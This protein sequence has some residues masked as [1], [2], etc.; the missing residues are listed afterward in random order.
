MDVDPDVPTPDVPTD[1]GSDVVADTV[2]DV[3]EDV[4]V[5]VGPD[6]V[7]TDPQTQIEAAHAAV[8][9]ASELPVMGSWDIDG[10]T[11]TYLKDAIGNDPAGFFIQAEQTGPGLFVMYADTVTMPAV[12]DTVAFTINA[13]T[14]T[15]GTRMATSITTPTVLTSGADVGALVQE[16]SDVD[17]VA[18]LDDYASELIELT[19]IAVGDFGFAGSG[20][21]AIS[22]QTDGYFSGTEIRLR[23]PTDVMDAV[24]ASGT[25]EGCEVSV[26][27]TPLWRFAATPQP[28]AQTIDELAVVCPAPELLAAAATG[29]TT[30]TLMFS[31]PIDAMSVTD[32]GTQFSIPGL[33]V[34]SA[35]VDET[36]VVLT[37]DAQTGGTVYTVTVA[38]SVVGADGQAL[39]AAANSADFSGFLP[40]DVLLINEVDYDNIGSD[41]S[42]YVEVYNPNA[43][44]VALADYVVTRVNGNN[45]T[46]YGTFALGGAGDMLAGESYLVLASQSLIDS[47]TID[48]GALT[49]PFDVATNN[50]QNGAPDAVYL[51]T[52]AGVFVDGLAY[53]GTVDGVGE[54]SSPGDTDSNT[55]EGS[56]SRCPNGADSDN[57]A[58]DFVF[59]PTLTP[60]TANACPLIE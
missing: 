46:A 13:L 4:G 27:G 49:V 10:A 52:A 25:I 32:P 53:E 6:T 40:P 29:P 39:D 51:A 50:L 60:G 41:V 11:V 17:L 42:E 28:S 43:F 31:R 9:E 2:S 23:M 47:M 22:I 44:P 18:E 15:D 57:N 54:G 48:A 55:I 34:A 30:V 35:V 36:S 26:L 37:T 59:T 21:E 14:E 58:A 7:V 3:I 1:T 5:D 19:G 20:F 33:T 45:G 38:T 8:A 24:T 56:L 12:G 16:V